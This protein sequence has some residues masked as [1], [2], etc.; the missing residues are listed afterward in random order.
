MTKPM[1][2]AMVVCLKCGA[3]GYSDREGRFRCRGCGARPRLHTE[4]SLRRG[5]WKFM[6]EV[7][8]LYAERPSRAQLK[9]T[10]DRLVQGQRFL[11]GQ[12]R[13][14]RVKSES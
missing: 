11:I 3:Q 13:P 10:V 6:R 14:R 9:I 2:N 5:A 8:A 4:A 12:P 1:P 7:S